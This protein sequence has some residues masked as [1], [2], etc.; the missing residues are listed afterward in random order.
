MKL[1]ASADS[2]TVAGPAIAAAAP[3]PRPRLPLN[4]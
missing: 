4:R 3:P 2:V 1:V